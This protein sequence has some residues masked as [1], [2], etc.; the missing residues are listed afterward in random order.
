MSKTK[1][2]FLGS[3]F[4]SLFLGCADVDSIML[5]DGPDEGYEFTNERL[6]EGYTIDESLVE[7]FTLTSDDNGD[8]A[9]I[10][11]SY[12]GDQSRISLDTVIL[13]CH[14]N[15]PSMDAFWP[16][17]G[18][19]ATIG[20]QHRFGVM[21]FDYRG[22]G[23]SEGAT[24][25]VGSFVADMEAAVAWL[26]ENGLTSDRLVVFCNSL[27]TIPGGHWFD[28]KRVM[29][30]EKLVFEVPQTSADAIARDASGLSWPSSLIT[31]TNFDMT[32]SLQN[33]QGPF[34]WMH[35]TIDETAP[36]DNA[37]RL[38]NRHPGSIKDSVIV[39]GA[40]HGLRWD[41][42]PKEWGDAILQFILK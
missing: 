23:K 12:I 11:A 8:Q 33:H 13:F 42:G 41:M 30:V 7:T 6:E 36:I 4:S 3:I 19:L 39:E 37:R 9:T 2:I 14:G 22:F 17:T 26:Q 32:E 20:G 18:H 35:G 31:D 5:A 15:A 27:G 1:M 29:E 10:F 28:E 21:T 34:L 25:T 38:F 40:G 24:T 16:M